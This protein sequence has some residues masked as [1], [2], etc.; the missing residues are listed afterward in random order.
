[1]V[2]RTETDLGEDKS[3]VF[4]E[5]GQ[6]GHSAQGG[7]SR[8]LNKVQSPRPTPRTTPGRV[9]GWVE[10]CGDA[11]EAGEAGGWRVVGNEVK[12]SREW[13]PGVREGRSVNLKKPLDFDL[14]KIRKWQRDTS[15]EE[16]DLP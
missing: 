8:A 3:A 6:E 7:L 10:G 15:R 4:F 11:G 2:R 14:N 5:G 12:T 9:R 1:M 13:D 16:Q